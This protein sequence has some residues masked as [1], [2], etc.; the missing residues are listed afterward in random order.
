VSEERE[1]VEFDRMAATLTFH[2]DG[3]TTTM[4]PEP[5]ELAYFADEPDQCEVYFEKAAAHF[6]Y[7]PYQKVS[8][9]TGPFLLHGEYG[10]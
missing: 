9:Y 4:C 6:V 3:L 5:E 8:L 2:V 7:L 10:R 1:Y